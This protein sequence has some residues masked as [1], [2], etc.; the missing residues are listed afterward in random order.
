MPQCTKYRLKGRTHCR[1]SRQTTSTDIASLHKAMNKIISLLESRPAGNSGR[2]G[3]NSGRPGPPPAPAPPPA[4]PPA[5][6]K[7][8]SCK[9]KTP[10]VRRA[11]ASPE[12]L[13]AE[14]KRKI[15]K[16]RV[17]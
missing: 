14:L 12:N 9:R 8:P 15:A 6:R 5:P 11:G 4:P 1:K 13:I 10:P 16:R 17:N 3:G 2:P 7:A